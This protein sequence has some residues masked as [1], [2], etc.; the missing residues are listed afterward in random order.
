MN[1]GIMKSINL[2]L[3]DPSSHAYEEYVIDHLS[4]RKCGAGCP[5][6]YVN[7]NNAAYACI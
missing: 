4:N 6:W 7:L 1:E 3:K 5:L 2:Y